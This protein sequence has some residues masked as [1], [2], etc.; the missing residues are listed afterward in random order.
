MGI[1]FF[2]IKSIKNFNQKFPNLWG[3]AT[4]SRESIQA[5]K[6]IEGYGWLNSLFNVAK[7][8]VF[9]H[10][11]HDPINSVK[12]TKVLRVLTYLSWKNAVNDTEN[13]YDE[14]MQDKQKR[15]TKK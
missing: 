12:L 5:G 14:L 11:N 3:G 8:G 13:K 7:D 2:F 4:G 10:P 6:I 1:L 15:R 9:T